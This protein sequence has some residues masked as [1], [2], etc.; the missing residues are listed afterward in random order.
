MRFISIFRHPPQGGAPDPRMYEEM[1]QFMAEAVRAGVLLHTEG[2]GASGP[3][4]ARVRLVDGQFTV[5]DGP[6]AETKEVIGGFA[7]M[8]AKSRD[9]M[10]EWTRRFL[11]ICGPGECEIHQISDV[12]PMDRIEK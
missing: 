5:T 8:Q 9:E 12:S 7:L 11:K 1:A 6:F 4:D 10:I 2:F 3:Q